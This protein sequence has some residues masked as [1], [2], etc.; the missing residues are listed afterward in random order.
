[1]FNVA[2]IKQFFR[3]LFNVPLTFR[4]IYDILQS[5]KRKERKSKNE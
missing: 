1:M 4:K 3:K 2:Y 5:Q